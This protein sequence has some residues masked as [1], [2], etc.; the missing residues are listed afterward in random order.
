MSVQRPSEDSLIARFF[1]PIAGEGALGLKDDAARL[2]PKPGHDLV[3][4]LDALV[5]RVHFCPRMRPGP[6]PAKRSA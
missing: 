6:L 5:E 4:T 3:L 1:A 2:S